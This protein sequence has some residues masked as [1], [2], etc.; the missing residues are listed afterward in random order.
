MP[1]KRNHGQHRIFGRIF[2]IFFA[3]ASRKRYNSVVDD[4]GAVLVGISP[5]AAQ[6]GPPLLCLVPCIS[7]TPAFRPFLSIDRVARAVLK[8]RPPG[9]VM[10]R[11]CF[12]EE[13]M[14]LQRSQVRET[15][16]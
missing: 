15:K 9:W 16:A 5:L 4:E 8:A 12:R 10:L 11:I 6:D 1:G 7:K 3:V 13:D 14:Y 2:L